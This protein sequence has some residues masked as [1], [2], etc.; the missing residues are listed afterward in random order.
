[1]AIVKGQ[2]ILASDVLALTT[3]REYL[4]G[5]AQ[6]MSETETILNEGHLS[7]VQKQ[8]HFYS[9]R[10]TGSRTITYRFYTALIGDAYSGTPDNSQV[11]SGSPG[12]YDLTTTIVNNVA[13]F[14]KFKVTFEVDNNGGTIIGDYS[15]FNSALKDSRIRFINADNSGYL[16]L[17]GNQVTVA[18]LD[19]ANLGVQ[20]A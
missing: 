17:N 8:E 14:K 18:S 5:P 13:K 6:V 12:G 16:T 4:K 11:L 3:K 2:K 20:D 7:P 10:V 1:M 9:L 19:N 15:N